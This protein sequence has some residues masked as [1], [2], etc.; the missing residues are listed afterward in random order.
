MLG[1]RILS[2]VM[3]VLIIGSSLFFGGPLWWALLLFISIVGYYEYMRAIRKIPEG[4]SFSLTAP[5]IAGYFCTAAYYLILLFRPEGKSLFYALVGSVILFMVVFVFLFSKHEATE[6]M[7]VFFGFL[8]IPVMISFMYLIRMRDR[9]VVE[10]LLVFIS[11]WICDTFA[12]FTGVA[13]GRHKL[14]PVLSPK[15][16]IEGAVGGTV[17]AVLAGMLLGSVIH[18]NIPE[19]GII[20]GAGAVISQFGDLFASGIKRNFGLK[21]YGT[22]IPGHGGIMDRFDSLIIVSPVIYFLCSIKEFI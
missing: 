17:A 12:Y 19:Y 22:L 15:K 13:I 21:D 8:Y 14:A 1:T 18:E 4:G 2:A 9:G 3:L 5:D 7:A 20:T 11:A 10:V 6:I 16:S